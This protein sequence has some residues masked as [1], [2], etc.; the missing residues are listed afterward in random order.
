MYEYIVACLRGG[1]RPINKLR[2]FA[3]NR[4]NVKCS[5]LSEFNILVMGSISN[6]LLAKALNEVI[7]SI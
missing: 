1:V 6:L 2:A 5:P 3:T 7:P 4:K